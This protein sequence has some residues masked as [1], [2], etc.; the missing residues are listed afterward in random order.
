MLP[1]CHRLAW[2]HGDSMRPKPGLDFPRFR[3][4]LG[5]RVP[6]EGEDENSQNSTNQL[7]AEG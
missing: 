4:R 5:Q 2:V 1:L 7:Y 6:V 3:L